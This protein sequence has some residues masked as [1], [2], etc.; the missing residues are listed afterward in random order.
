MKTNDTPPWEKPEP[1]SREQAMFDAGACIGLAMTN[2]PEVRL[3]AVERAALKRAGIALHNLLIQFWD[4]AD[5]ALQ[6]QKK[7]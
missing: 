1:I 5:A 7:P 3:D 2:R 4:V 6:E